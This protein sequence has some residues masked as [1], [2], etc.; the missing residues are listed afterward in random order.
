MVAVIHMCKA[1]WETGGESH[2]CCSEGL[3]G[4]ALKASR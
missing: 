1:G 2:C 4:E 3:E